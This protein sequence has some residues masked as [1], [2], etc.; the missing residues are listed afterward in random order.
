VNIQLAQLRQGT[1]VDLEDG[2]YFFSIHCFSTFIYLLHSEEDFEAFHALAHRTME[3][4]VK[5]IVVG[6]HDQSTGA[7][8][9]PESEEQTGFVSAVCTSISLQRMKIPYRFFSRQR[10]RSIVKTAAVTTIHKA[11]LPCGPRSR[12]PAT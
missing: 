10:G 12:H 11:L 5:V 1:A 3:V 8:G 6:V 7:R 2:A 4:D 9:P